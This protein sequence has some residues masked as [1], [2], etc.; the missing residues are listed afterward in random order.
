MW[1]RYRPRS[2]ENVLGEVM[3]LVQEYSPKRLNF[4]DDTFAVNKKRTIN[5]CQALR[6]KGLDVP[7]TAMTRVGVDGE[8]L[9]EMY[10]AGCRL[11]YFGCESGN[12]ST[13]KTV[14]KG[15]TTSQIER[16]VKMA[17]QIGYYAVCSFIINLPYETPEAARST[18]AFAKKLK[19]MGALIQAHSLAPYPGTEVYDEPEKYDLT[20]KHRGIE[21]WRILSHPLYLA[22]QVEYPPQISNSLITE[23][24]LAKLWSEVAS[25]FDYY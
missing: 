6:Q 11:L 15:I 3:H 7:W 25:V 23:Q 18:I 10:N 14:T 1:T 13:L 19:D 4:V 5:F 12:D 9:Q 8:L 24:E 21:L 2:V 16:T 17:L 20:L 22:E